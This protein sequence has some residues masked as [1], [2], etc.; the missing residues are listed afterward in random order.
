MT[1]SNID[2]YI[3]RASIEAAVLGTSYVL[4]GN[5]K[6]GELVVKNV[7]NEVL[8]VK[9]KNWDDEILFQLNHIKNLMVDIKFHQDIRYA[10][11]WSSIN[12]AI[13]DMEIKINKDNATEEMES[14]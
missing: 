8:N 14:I 10:Q 4:V 12:D 11:I 7:T 5:D 9:T 13:D 2:E 1:K 3:T 6:D